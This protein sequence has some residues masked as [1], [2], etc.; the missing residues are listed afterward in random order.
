MT[1]TT[2][3]KPAPWTEDGKPVTRTFAKVSITDEAGVGTT[4]IALSPDGWQDPE[5]IRHLHTGDTITR[6][7]VVRWRAGYPVREPGDERVC[8]YCWRPVFLE[9]ERV[10]G[11]WNLVYQEYADTRQC[12]ARGDGAA[13]SHLP[14]DPWVDSRSEFVCCKTPIP[15]PARGGDPVTCPQCGSKWEHDGVDLGG[16]ARQVPGQ[17]PYLRTAFVPYADPAVRFDPALPAPMVYSPGIHDEC[18]SQVRE[19]PDSMRRAALPLTLGQAVTVTYYRD[20]GD[21]DAPA[22]FYAELDPAAN[23]GCTAAW[24]GSTTERGGFA[25][26]VTLPEGSYPG[27]GML[28]RCP[29]CAD[30]WCLATQEVW[31][32]RTAC[33][34]CGYNSYYSIGD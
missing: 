11:A 33:A 19:V 26:I 24:F 30:P 7:W 29:D 34:A 4:T 20:L 27:S 8:R 6:A 32:N 28:V 3:A 2:P 12:D 5:F 10:G 25:L 23:H 21:A 1:S 14:H 15:F 16:G 31:G 17:S 22:R 18:V 13:L 9:P